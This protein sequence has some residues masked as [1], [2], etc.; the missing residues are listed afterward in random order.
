MPD[1]HLVVCRADSFPD[2]I[3]AT[4]DNLESK[5]ESLKGRKFYGLT[6]LEPSGL[7]YYAGLET[8]DAAEI[9]ALGFPTLLVTGGRCARVRLADWEEHVDQISEIFDW[10]IGNYDK[11]PNSPSIE[12]YRSRSELLLYIRLAESQP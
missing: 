5:L 2:G 4:W 8:T 7:A 1:L 10:L 9:S 3:P 6:Y 11:D 12:Y